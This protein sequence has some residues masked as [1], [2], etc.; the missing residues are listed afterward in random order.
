MM[1]R[2]P[3][4]NQGLLG[5]MRRVADWRASERG[6]QAAAFWYFQFSSGAYPRLEGAI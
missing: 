4:T 2:M 5:K 1:P 3:G 6:R